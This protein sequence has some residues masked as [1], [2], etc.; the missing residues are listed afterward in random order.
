MKLIDKYN[1]LRSKDDIT[2]KEK[3]ILDA[4]EYNIFKVKPTKKDKVEFEDLYDVK[5]PKQV[6]DISKSLYYKIKIR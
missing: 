2:R 6:E 1:E 3:V 4:F 5:Y